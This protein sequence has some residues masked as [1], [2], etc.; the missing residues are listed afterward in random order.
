[1]LSVFDLAF[2]LFRL[3]ALWLSKRIGSL[4]ATP[5]RVLSSE[6]PSAPPSKL[7]TFFPGDSWLQNKGP[8]RIKPTSYFSLHNLFVSVIY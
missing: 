2:N 1:M 3:F 8:A 7:G 4:P 6:D 5:S